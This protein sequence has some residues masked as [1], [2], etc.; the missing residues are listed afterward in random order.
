MKKGASY[1]VKYVQLLNAPNIQWPLLKLG[2]PDPQ[3][4]GFLIFASPPRDDSLC[5][6]KQVKVTR[7]GQK[8]E[9]G[10]VAD[11]FLLC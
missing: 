2:V 1:L 6:V 7:S 4:S 3:H 9:G 11:T 10:V 8:R 5:L